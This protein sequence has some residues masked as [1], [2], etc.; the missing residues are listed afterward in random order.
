MAKNKESE[1]L[2]QYKMRE[3]QQ[4]FSDV[5]AQIADHVKANTVQFQTV[6]EKLDAIQLSLAPVTLAQKQQDARIK[7]LEMNQWGA[8]VALV[9][10][11]AGIIWYAVKGKLFG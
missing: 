10:T 4:G 1:D 2:R 6:N 8:L 11:M 5:N 9:V 3:L 7:K